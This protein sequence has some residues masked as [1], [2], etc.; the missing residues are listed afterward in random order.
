MSKKQNAAE[1]P[2]PQK[3]NTKSIAAITGA[4]ETQDD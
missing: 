2:R 1:A 4:Q 3:R